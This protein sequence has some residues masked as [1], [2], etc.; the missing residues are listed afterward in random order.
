MC[1]V[2]YKN[3]S[4][5]VVY[6]ML[7]FTHTRRNPKNSKIIVKK[8][9]SFKVSKKS[10]EQECLEIIQ[11]SATIANYLKTRIHSWPSDRIK[12]TDIFCGNP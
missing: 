4:C 3:L 7:I 2:P 12:L 9:M 1:N 6:H 5:R 10:P 11:L 8:I